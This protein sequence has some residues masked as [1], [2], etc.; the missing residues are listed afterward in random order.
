MDR[1]DVESIGFI[2]PALADEF[3]WRQSLECFQPPPVIVGID[4]VV[5][6]LFQVFMIVV[7]IPFDRRFLDR[8]VHAFDL[9]IGPWVSDF[10]QSVI[11]V[12]LRTDTIKDVNA[13]M[14]VTGKVGELDTV[15]CQNC[16]ECIRHGLD[17]IV[18]KC[19]RRHFSCF[20]HQL[21]KGEF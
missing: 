2:C 1:I 20:L 7:M 8:A 11:N 18:Q 4:K 19:C 3:V 17:Q 14:F 10:C 16:V 12:M 13:G 15:V 6:V 21:N 9:A 5:K